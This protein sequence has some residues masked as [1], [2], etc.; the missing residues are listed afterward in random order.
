MEID[1]ENIA[2]AAKE[3]LIRVF[4]TAEIELIEGEDNENDKWDLDE[5]L[6]KLANAQMLLEMAIHDLNNVLSIVAIKVNKMRET[7]K[8]IEDH[9]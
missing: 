3:A 9:L 1:T 4:D 5:D 2:P 6:D 7:L 8:V